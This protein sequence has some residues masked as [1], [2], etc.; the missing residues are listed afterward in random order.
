MLATYVGLPQVP[1]Q[2]PGPEVLVA[3]VPSLPLPTP[4][5]ET[6]AELYGLHDRLRTQL[7]R[8]PAAMLVTRSGVEPAPPTLLD[9]L[10]AIQQRIHRE[11]AAQDLRQR[12]DRLA[13]AAL[14][15]GD[16]ATLPPASVEA[17][18]GLWAETMD[19]LA[20]VP[21]GSLAA[22]EAARQR[23][24]YDRQFAIAAHRYD[25]AR[26][27]FLAAIAEQTGA[28]NRLRITVCTLQR[29]CRRWQG[30]RPPA[31]PASLIKVPVAVALMHHLHSQGIAASTPLWVSPG[32][33]TED[34]GRTWVG[35]EYPIETIL[36]DMVSASGN[37]AT[38]QLIDYLG[39]TGVGQALRDRGYSTTRV[40][41][42]LVGQATYPTNAGHQPNTTTTDEITDMMVGIYNHEHPGD[43]LIRAALHN[44]VDLALGHAA[45]APP[46][47]WL[48]EKTGRNSKVLGSTSAVVV[49]GQTY[50]I[51]TTLDHSG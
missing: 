23:S 13:A 4:T 16:P 45:V 48:G 20:Q 38:N 11:E 37:I 34:A 2:A 17:A 5:P 36:A 49:A 40:S 21:E 44:Q 31:S 14:A 6:L 28:A 41:R 33:W 10:W 8:Y 51:T 50:I 27:D 30:D 43:D 18:H 47:T 39:Y 22:A 9:S 35:T 25:T 3:A 32:N 42:K 15:L 1:A 12:A 29:H 7:E 24:H 19:A 46:A 26:S